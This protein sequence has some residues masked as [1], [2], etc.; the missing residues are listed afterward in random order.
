MTQDQQANLDQLE[1]NLH[2]VE[3][4]EKALSLIQRLLEHE[5]GHLGKTAREDARKLLEEVQE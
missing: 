5:H 2:V 1:A 4:L 3:A